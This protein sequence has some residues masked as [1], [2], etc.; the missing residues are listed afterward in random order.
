MFAEGDGEVNGTAIE[1][2]VNAT[3]QLILHKGRG[4]HNPGRT[5]KNPVLETPEL[6]IT[7]GFNED[8][9]EAAR[10][11]VLE[12]IDLLVRDGASRASRHT[13]CAPS[14]AICA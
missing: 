3:I 7:H 4:E 13:R 8:L 12:M 11:A 10:E 6:W 2:H 9:D 5:M 14:P 1:A